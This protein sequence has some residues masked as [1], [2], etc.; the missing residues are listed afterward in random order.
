MNNIKN[1]KLTLAIYNYINESKVLD[2]IKNCEK[3]DTINID[4]N[5]KMNL[6]QRFRDLDLLKERVIQKILQKER[7]DKLLIYHTSFLLY[8]Y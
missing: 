2:K 4:D 8:F 3:D 7:Y 6:K 5:F 1:N